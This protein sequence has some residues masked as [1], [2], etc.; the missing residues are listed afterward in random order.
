MEVFNDII[1]G[2]QEWLEVRSGIPTASC[3]D[4][5]ITPT[6]KKSD[7]SDEYANLLTAEKLLEQPIA[8]WKGN[9]WTERGNVLEQDAVDFYEFQHDLVTEKVGFVK[10]YGVGC[11]PDR[12]I[13]DDGL[14]EGK[15]PAPHT[16]VGYMLKNALP[17][18]FI[19]QVQGQLYVTNRKWCDWMSFHPEMGQVIIRVKRD[20]E[21]IT[22]MS[23]LLCKFLEKLEEKQ[24]RLGELGYL[25]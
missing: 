19:P 18:L 22:T 15:A 11:S 1:Q 5:I 9:K 13:G 23:G 12:L 8:T 2:T 14:L 20:E 25:Q 3:F 10:N 21:Y 7:S 24:K 17:T 6:G 4:K 16:H